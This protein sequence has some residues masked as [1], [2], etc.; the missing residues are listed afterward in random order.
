MLR[1]GEDVFRGFEWADVSAR[2]YAGFERAR[3]CGNV[4]FGAFN[5]DRW[6]LKLKYV[7]RGVFGVEDDD[8]VNALDVLGG[9][10]VH[11]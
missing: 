3:Q 1:C 4:V 7:G 8:L 2:Y 9:K 5:G 10:Q 11:R 6:N